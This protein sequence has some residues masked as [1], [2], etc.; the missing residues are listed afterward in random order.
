MSQ[1][2]AA[3]KPSRLVIRELQLWP[4]TLFRRAHD[5]P[6]PGTFP[7][8]TGNGRFR[9]TPARRFMQLCSSV[10]S[11]PQP[12]ANALH[13]YHFTCS[14]LFSCT[15]A[16]CQSAHDGSLTFARAEGLH[17]EHQKWRTFPPPP[18]FRQLFLYSLPFLIRVC[19]AGSL[20]PSL[21][22]KHVPL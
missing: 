15:S 11:H 6:F 12:A 20:T 18:S 5:V 2:N 17:A 21:S 16:H 19:H 14:L 10:Q 4:V 13:L 9:R 1:S 22:F 3:G 7:E 8:P